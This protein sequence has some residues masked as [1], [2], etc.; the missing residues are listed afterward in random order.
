MSPG[1]LVLRVPVIAGFNDDDGNMQALADFMVSARV[2]EV[3]RLPFHRL[4]ESKW[5][6]LGTAY[7]WRER[8]A[9]AQVRL[10]ALARIFSRQ[11][12]N[13]YLGSDTPF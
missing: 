7:P 4:G 2:D 6:Q 5:R 12:L 11:G 8:Q 10:D 9:P 1:R 13:C 3:N